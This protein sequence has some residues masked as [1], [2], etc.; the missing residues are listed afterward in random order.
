MALFPGRTAKRLLAGLF[1][2]ALVGGGAWL[3]ADWYRE[4]QAERLTEA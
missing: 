4:K 3:A 2:A 1:G